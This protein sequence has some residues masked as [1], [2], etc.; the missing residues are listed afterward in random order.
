VHGVCLLVTNSSIFDATAVFFERNHRS[1]SV[2][3][4][5]ALF[6]TSELGKEMDSLLLSWRFFLKKGKDEI[7]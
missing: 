3:A 6:R 1:R 4:R 5:Y 2:T 7:F